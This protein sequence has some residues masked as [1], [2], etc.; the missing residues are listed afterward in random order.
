[1]AMWT[2]LRGP[3]T[4]DIKVGYKCNNRCV[5]CVVEP[6]RQELAINKE[7]LNLETN[8]IMS[9]IDKAKGK[10]ID[11]IVLTGGEITI[12]PDFE[13]IVRY[14]V[15]KGFK[16]DIQTNGRKLA[17]KELCDSLKNLP[18]LLFIIALHADRADIHDSITREKGSFQ[19]T[20]QAIKNLRYMDME[21]AA[22]IVLSNLNYHRLYNTFQFAK[23]LQVN[24]FCVTF[25]HADGFPKE[26]FKQIVPRYSFISEQIDQIALSCEKNRFRC[27]FETIPYCVCPKSKAFWIR[28]CDLISYIHNSNDF[29]TREEDRSTPERKTNI[30]NGKINLCSC[31]GSKNKPYCDGTHRAMSDDSLF[32]WEILRPEMK[33]KWPNCKICVFDH[34]CEGPWREY[35]QTFGFSEFIPITSECVNN[36]IN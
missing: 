6:A 25:P 8:T 35:V 31:G 19:E 13:E 11:T 15:N 1:M 32:D 5:H 34:L 24:E 28:N 16:V 4:L 12:R 22:K 27:S 20:V 17:K 36:L 18:G 21:I 30:L 23:T 3:D 14:A 26:L 2:Y 7:P 33:Q 29:D 10:K 9:I